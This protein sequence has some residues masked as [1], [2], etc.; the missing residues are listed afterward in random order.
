MNSADGRGCTAMH[1]AAYHN[2]LGAIEA[3][4]KAGGDMKKKNAYGWTPLLFAASSC[5]R[6]VMLDLLE[7]GAD[8]N[9]QS[10]KGTTPLHQ[11]CIGPREGLEA[12]VKLL[13]QSGADRTIID[14]KNRTAADMID[15]ILEDDEPRCSQEEADRVRMLLS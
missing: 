1:V 12:A 4:V 8:V 13:V 7:R 9:V 14:S 6:A 5:S 3:L 15:S 10:S 11:A 2:Q